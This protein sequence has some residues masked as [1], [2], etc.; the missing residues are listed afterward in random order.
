MGAWLVGTHNV[1]QNKN[2]A[3]MWETI[4]RSFGYKGNGYGWLK[5]N[6]YGYAQWQSLRSVTIA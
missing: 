3:N 6:D 5:R 2:E 4:A 1:G